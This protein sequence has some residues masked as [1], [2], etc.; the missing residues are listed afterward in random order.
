M[1]LS[2]YRIVDLTHVIVP[3]TEPRPVH[4]ERVPAP[5]APEDMWYIMHRFEMTLNHVGTHI[6]TPYHVR[7]DGM[8]VAGYPVEKL[9]G[10]AVVLDLRFVAPGGVVSLDDITQAA[11]ASGGI[12]PGDIVLGRFDPQGEGSNRNFTAEAIT[13]LVDAGMSLM[14]VD[15][16][17][18]EL[19][20]SDPRAT[21]QYNHHQLLDRDI[22]LI[23]QVANLK[24]LTKSRCTIFALPIPIQGIDSFPIRLLAFEEK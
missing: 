19:P 5:H 14:G 18:I 16:N 12:Q 4:I 7:Q 3:D 20:E 6:E 2:R 13:Y 10:P 1:D 9:C 15:L 17:G 24:D 22:C 21:L 11:E 8:D 23:E